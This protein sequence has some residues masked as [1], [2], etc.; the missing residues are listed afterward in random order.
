MITGIG[1]TSPIQRLNAMNA[2]KAAEAKPQEKIIPEVSDGLD[3]NNTDIL[4]NQNIQEIKDFAKIAGEENISE[5]DIKY[6]VTYGR[7]VIAEYIA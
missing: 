3:I 4:K 1:V 7:S 5:D 2:F 6:G